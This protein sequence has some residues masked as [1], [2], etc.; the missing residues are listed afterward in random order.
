MDIHEP[1][2]LTAIVGFLVGDELTAGFWVEQP[3]MGASDAKE[4]GSNGKGL[5]EHGR[6]G[7]TRKIDEG[8]EL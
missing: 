8:I 6:G 5:E 3:E 4:A 7:E 2:L 1:A